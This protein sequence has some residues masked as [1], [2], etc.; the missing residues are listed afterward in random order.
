M[1]E[2]GSGSQDVE[3]RIWQPGCGSEDLE[4]KIMKKHWLLFEK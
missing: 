3:A 4:A 1:W 2:P